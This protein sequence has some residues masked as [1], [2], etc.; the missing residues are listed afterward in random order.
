[1]AAVTAFD[2]DILSELFRGSAG[3][4]N[5]ALTIPSDQHAIPIVVVEEVLRGRLNVVRQAE[6]GKARVSLERAYDLLKQTISY[7]QRFLVLPYTADADR[8]F[9]EWRAEKI[10]VGTHDL[11]IAAICV[12]HGATLVSRNRRDFDLLRDLSVEFWA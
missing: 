7:F 12:S 6:A 3:Y 10:R 5:R 2:A 9:Q 4:V 8:I 1:M 11:R